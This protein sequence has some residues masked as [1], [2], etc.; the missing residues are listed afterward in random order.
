MLDTLELDF[1]GWFY[2]IACGIVVLFGLAVFAVLYI[3]G[4]LAARYKDY[5]ILNDVMLLMIWVIGFGGALG[6]L[7]RVLHD[8]H[9]DALE[10]LIKGVS[11]ARGHWR[12]SAGARQN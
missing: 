10:A 1:I 3:K 9:G 7:E 12:L 5:N 4:Q 6:V 8:C 11:Q 2:A